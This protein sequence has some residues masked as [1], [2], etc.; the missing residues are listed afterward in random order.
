M[1]GEQRYTNNIVKAIDAIRQ[2]KMFLLFDAEGREAE[3]DL[4]ILA[5]AVTPEDVKIMRKDGGGLICVAL[6][7]IACE[8]MDLPFM[9]DVVRSAHECSSTLGT[10]VEKGGDLRYDSRS[11]FSI[12]VNHRNTRTG[13]PDNDR[14]I[15]I[16]KLGD[17]VEKVLAG[18]NVNFGSEFRTPGHVATLRAAKGLI[19]E[20]LGQTE[21][22]IALAKIADVTPA[23]V[24]CEM[25]DDNT[26]RALSKEDA[27]I[28]AEKHGMIFIEGSEVIEAYKIW[29][30]ATSIPSEKEIYYNVH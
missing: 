28:Y 26:G 19:N 22:S 12:W 11:S 8:Y 10:T 5:Q 3:T 2:G 14:A 7:P 25:L 21:L 30:S 9:A 16:K 18:E 24:V 1:I 20:R 13:I 17:V 27:K 4:T 6:D 15:T 23:M 29:A